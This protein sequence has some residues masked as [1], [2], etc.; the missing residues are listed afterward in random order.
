MKFLQIV[1][2]LIVYIFSFPAIADNFCNILALEIEK[3]LPQFTKTPYYDLSPYY[4]FDVIEGDDYLEVTHI[5]QMHPL[6]GLLTSD[7]GEK[8]IVIRNHFEINDLVKDDKS[9]QKN[10]EIEISKKQ[11][12]EYNHSYLK[13][14]DLI[15]SINGKDITDKFIGEE[16][17]DY[18]DEFVSKE[19]SDII[20]NEY[21]GD[22]ELFIFDKVV[23]HRNYRN[24]LIDQINARIREIRDIS[25]KVFAG[26]FGLPFNKEKLKNY[27]R[28][29]AE[30]RER[31]DYRDVVYNYRYP[32]N[33]HKLTLGI[34]RPDAFDGDIDENGVMHFTE[35][36]LFYFDVYP[37]Y[38]TDNIDV[39]V[40]YEFYDIRNIDVQNNIFTADYKLK[41]RWYDT[42]LGN[43]AAEIFARNE[44]NFNE[45][46]EFL[47][48]PERDNRCSYDNSDANYEIISKVWRPDYYK[49]NQLSTEKNKYKENIT[50]MPFL[51]TIHD[52]RKNIL[53][54]TQTE[55]G[56]SQFT[57]N[58]DYS[59][60]PF[61][62]QTLS[63]GIEQKTQRSFSR[64]PYSVSDRFNPAKSI[65]LSKSME[66]FNH[67]LSGW[68]M[69][70]K[71]INQIKFEITE[72]KDDRKINLLSN[73]DVLNDKNF[74]N[75]YYQIKDRFND[76]FTQVIIFSK[77]IDRNWKYFVFKIIAPIILI[78]VVCWSIFWTPS[79]ELE[80]RLTVTITC[81]LAL[82]A[83]TF[84]ID[85]DLPKLSYLTLMDYIIL[86]SYFYAAMPTI[87]SV[88]SHKLYNQNNLSNIKLDYY[89]KFLG[90]ITYVLLIYAIIF[91]TVSSN[92]SIPFLKAITFQ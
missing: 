9:A 82:V 63:I 27:L 49:L 46:G 44:K 83:Y 33:D 28:R 54:V 40:E 58:F 30:G 89:A 32:V 6:S 12:Q 68:E 36:D 41:L 4:G 76:E 45:Y 18:F 52:S 69:A 81:F 31:A 60:F 11:Y 91:G 24:D 85:D 20:K 35:K 14:G 17:L 79:R 65:D 15:Y 75:S 59:S 26:Y 55:S 67:K 73:Y 5:N 72:I 3:N 23:L 8:Q 61:D 77:K 66:A 25:P 16:F 47:I 50:I 78:L 7:D 84:V 88:I 22:K 2:C 87:L 53:M 42:N 1:F 86:I 51:Q 57:L 90:P 34:F 48:A 71:P 29:E 70:E 92:N 21:N 39:S 43:L 13:I 62:T 64:L 37:S 38:N 80:S 74:E 10:K 56:T 19:Y